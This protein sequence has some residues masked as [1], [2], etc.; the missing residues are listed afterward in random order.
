MLSLLALKLTATRRVSHV[1]DLLIRPGRGA[2]GRPGDLAE[3]IR[4]HRLLLP[5]LPRPPAD[6]PGRPGRQDDRRRARLRRG[7]DLRPGLP[8][9]HALGPRPGAGK[10]LRAHPV[11]ARPLGA[12]LLRPG[13]RHSQ[14]RLRQRRHLQGHPGPRGHRLLRP[15]ESRQ[16]D[17]P[18]DAGHG[19]EGHHPGRPRRARRARRQVPH[20]AHALGR[21]W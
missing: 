5:A 13:L 15:L 19:P 12:D 2:A 16:R 18:E 4:A 10:A 21:P 9:R 17:R 7:S 3:E 11:P 14:P 6:V 20:P 8:R 1:D